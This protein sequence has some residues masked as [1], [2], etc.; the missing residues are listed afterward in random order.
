MNRSLLYGCFGCSAALL[1]SLSHA[2]EGRVWTDPLGDAAIRRTDSGAY[3]PL[4]QG[5]N[6]PDILSLSI[7]GWNP[8]NPTVDPYV[9]NT[10]PAASAAIFRLDLTLAGLINPPGS[11]QFP[12]TP[13]QYGS[14]PIYGFIDFDVDRDI[15]TGGEVAG[16]RYNYLEQIAR[17]GAVPVG[18]LAQRAVT[19]RSQVDFDF[20]TAPFY[21]RSGADFTLT[22]CGCNPVTIVSK[23]VGGNQDNIFDAGETWIVRSKFFQRSAAYRCASGTFEGSELGLYE[24]LVNLRFHHDIPSNRTTI[25]LVFPLTMQGAATLA[26]QPVQP[27]NYQFTGGSHFSVFEALSD[28]IATVNRGGATGDCQIIATNWQGRNA[29]NYL[30]VANWN[31][32]AIVGTT[33]AQHPVGASFVWTDVGFANI[34]GDF[35]GDGRADASDLS[36]L[37]TFLTANDGGPDD[38]DGARNN[39]VTLFDFPFNYSLYDLNYDGVVDVLDLNML[40]PSCAADWDGINGLNTSDFFAFLT[41]FFNGRA[42]FNNDG[43]T[44]SAD[45]LAFMNAFFA[46][47]N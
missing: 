46:N 45:F 35:N 36:A 37:Q 9:G 21:E 15:D 4:I 10:V 40:A 22:F 11:I 31:V 30:N 14:N 12:D 5:A 39:A 44:N 38:A 24:P 28:V 6:L 20:Y 43:I 1:A 3:A 47:C 17:F 23:G 29:A 42:D 32:N 34:V 33:Y 19:S 2:Q 41:D 26:G 7:K 8:I 16:G 25:S 18:P 27:W 13:A